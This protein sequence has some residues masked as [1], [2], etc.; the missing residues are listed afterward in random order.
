MIHV[1]IV[2]STHVFGCQAHGFFSTGQDGTAAGMKG[3]V[4][5]G[6]RRRSIVWGREIREQRY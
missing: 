1:G 6:S 3:P 5:F 2:G 4:E